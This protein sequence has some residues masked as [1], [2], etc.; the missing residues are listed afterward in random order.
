METRYN[1]VLGV[2]RSDLR[3][4]QVD[5]YNPLFSPS[6]PPPSTHEWPVSTVDCLI[7]WTYLLY[8]LPYFVN[9]LVQI[10]IINIFCL[11]ILTS[12][13][14]YLVFR[15][16]CQRPASYCHAVVCVRPSFRPSVCAC[17]RKL[18]LQK[19]S[20]QK[21]LTGFLRNFTGIFPRWSSF[22]LFQIIVFYEQFWLPWRSK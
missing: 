20:P 18:F 1:V 4:I 10:K 2:H 11:P 19:T 13:K 22:K 21:L 8:K 5:G 7:L 9:V 12:I 16:T 14:S 15:S 6:P 17:I 3:Y